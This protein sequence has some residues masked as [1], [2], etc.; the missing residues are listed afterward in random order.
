[1]KNRKAL[2]FDI[3]GT[4]FSDRLRQ[5]PQSAVLALKKTR[6]QGNLVFIN[7]GRTWCQTREIRREVET[8]GLCCGCGTYLTGIDSECLGG[9]NRPEKQK[10]LYDRQIPLQ[11][12]A[13]IRTAL[14]QFRVDAVLEGVD[15]CWMAPGGPRTETMRRIWEILNASG[16]A[17]ADG[18]WDPACK[19][20]K[21][22]VSVDK[23]SSAEE[24]FRTIPD[25]DVIDRGGGFYECVPQ[26]H[27][28]A[29]AIESVLQTY[30]IAKKDAWVFG[31]STND[32]AM[33]QYAENAVLM[34]AHDKELEPYATFVTR[35]V[36]EDGIFWAMEQLGLL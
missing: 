22:C 18:W 19:I 7:T 14:E 25:F 27:S 11:R 1:M 17:A 34:G 10:I 33:F 9:L 6:K 20:S 4:L 5:V 26:G 13:E 8:D 21:F 15:S 28:K 16:S 12:A 23:E 35:T 36:E 29:T 31:D 30:G 32:L 2:F 24:F 3:D